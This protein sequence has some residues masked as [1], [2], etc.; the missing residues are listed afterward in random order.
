MNLVPQFNN[1]ELTSLQTA[2]VVE[3]WK[4]KAYGRGK[5]LWE[6]QFSQ[7]ERDLAEKLYK[8]FLHWYTGWNG[9]GVPNKAIMSL[10]DYNFTRKLVGFFA[11]I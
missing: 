3:C 10:E 7:K 6:V 5:R 4:H 11:T 1:Q 8:T 9:S 2:I